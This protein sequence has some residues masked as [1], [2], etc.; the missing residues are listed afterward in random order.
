MITQAEA[1][2]VAR[3]LAD[4]NGWAW[5]EPASAQLRRPWRGDGGRAGRHGMT[6]VAFSR[7]PQPL[8]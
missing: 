4:E 5:T 6:F 1:I 2:I 7:I 3:R 8:P